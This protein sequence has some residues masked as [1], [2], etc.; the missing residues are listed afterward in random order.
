MVNQRRLRWA[1]SLRLLSRYGRL[2]VLGLLALVALLW[3]LS[4]YRTPARRFF[5]ALSPLDAQH[6]LLLTSKDPS[7]SGAVTLEVVDHTGQR[8]WSMPSDDFSPHEIEGALTAVADEQTIYLYGLWPDRSEMAVRALER[9]SGAQRW[10]RPLWWP[11]RTLPEGQPYVARALDPSVGDTL[12]L[13]GPR[14]YVRH[15]LGSERGQTRFALKVLDTRTGELLW[16]RD[17]PEGDPPQLSG[18]MALLAPGRLLY[19]DGFGDATLLDGESGRVLQTI[20][21]V[22]F[23]TCVLPQAVVLRHSTA[24]PSELQIWRPEGERYHATP[25]RF[26]ENPT[27]YAW[28]SWCTQRDGDL[29]LPI[30]HWLQRGSRMVSV[31]RIDPQ[32]GRTQWVV[33]TAAALT[34]SARGEHYAAQAP[35]FLALGSTLAQEPGAP[36]HQQI[37]TV[38]L[39]QGELVTLRNVQQSYVALNF[40]GGA[41]FAAL[42]VKGGPAL[43][44]VQPD[45]GALTARLAAQGMSLPTLHSG[46]TPSSEALWLYRRGW[47]PLEHGPIWLLLNLN[48]MTLTHSA[49]PH[50]PQIIEQEQPP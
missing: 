25:I 13:D 5:A 28:A 31:A 40:P 48:T 18:S 23:V 35:R 20:E 22:S 44:Q 30:Y 1:L 50:S 7:V 15:A 37:A 14:L 34:I 41:Y 26:P 3:V 49:G 9:G 29:I 45:S 27:Y 19:L 21:R 17:L 38:D 46:L 36:M 16:Q 6:A 43:L 33:E 47:Y 10:T 12:L 4:T 32:T 24:L 39:D 42:Q 8:L 11:Q 2:L